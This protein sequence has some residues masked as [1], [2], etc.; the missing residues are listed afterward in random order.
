VRGGWLLT[1]G[2]VRVEEDLGGL[3]WVAVPV[4]GELDDV[5]V[6]AAG[7]AAAE[8]SKQAHCAG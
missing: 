6:P 1:V 7:A 2:W 5:E 8:W 4:R 3:R